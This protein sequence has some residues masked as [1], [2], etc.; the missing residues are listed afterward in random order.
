MRIYLDDVVFSLKAHLI[1]LQKV[2]DVINEAG[3]KL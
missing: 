2:F 1:H 3:L